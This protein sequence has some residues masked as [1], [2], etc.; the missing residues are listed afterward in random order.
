M[1]HHQLFAAEAVIFA[2]LHQPQQFGLKRQ[3]QFRHFI[4]KQNATSGALGKAAMIGLVVAPRYPKSSRS[5]TSAG[6]AAQLTAMNG[7]F[8]RAE[9]LWRKRAQISLPAPVSPVI[10]TGLVRSQIRRSVSSTCRICGDAPSAAPG[11]GTALRWIND[12]TRSM[13]LPTSNGLV[14]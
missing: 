10:S 6:M 7:S 1:K 8:E 3:R 12:R 14:T 4:E 11:F 9:M 5:I 13:T 2:C